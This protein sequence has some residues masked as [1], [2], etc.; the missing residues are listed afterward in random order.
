[1]EGLAVVEAIEAARVDGE[2]PKHRIEVLRA[3][4]DRGASGAPKIP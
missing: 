2:K 3:R 4:V 1:M